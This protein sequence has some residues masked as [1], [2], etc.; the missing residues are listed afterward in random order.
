M[1]EIRDILFV[2]SKAGF[3]NK[4]LLA[5][6]A[7][8]RRNGFLHEGAPMTPGFRQI[9]EPGE[10]L[11]VMLVL[12]DGQI[13]I[14]EGMSVILAG[15]AG[16]DPI[17]RPGEMLTLLNQHVQPLLAGRNVAHARRLAEE[18]DTL[19]IDGKP[20]H[21]AA[22]YGVTQAVFQAAALARGLLPAEII[23]EQYNTRIARAP[24]PIMGAAEQSDAG[25]VDRII[26]KRADILPHGAFSSIDRDLGSD[27]SKL[28]IYAAGLAAR[29][30]EIGAADYCPRIHFDMYGSIGALFPDPTDA[31]A[32]LDRVATAVAPFSL[33]IESPII[34]ATRTQQFDSYRRLKDALARRNSAVGIVIDEWC[35]DLDDVRACAELGAADFVQI[36]TPDLGGI[37]NAIEAVLLCRA[38][39]MGSCLGGSANET[40][41]SARMTA[42]IALACQPDFLMSKPGLG[43]DE[44]FM[45]LSNEMIRSLALMESRNRAP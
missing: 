23:S 16:R 1:T 18:I 12:D 15:V 33:L 4:D 5:S 24:L 35:N 39:G 10:A 28:L 26:L 29:I 7:S 40:D 36:K 3:F 32:Y 41:I 13:A 20:L 37:N 38:A 14:G 27:G 45:I 43:F 31:A 9:V 2:P 17:F 8:N 11:S 25:L 44:G 42:Q 22:R 34:E 19:M 21:S 6:A 30:K